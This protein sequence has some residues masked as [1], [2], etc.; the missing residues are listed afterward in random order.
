LSD[1]ENAIRLALAEWLREDK[2]LFAILGILSTL[3]HLCVPSY[4]AT[5][6]ARAR[7][8]GAVCGTQ[9]LLDE[10]LPMS[11]SM[12]RELWHQYLA[13]LNSTDDANVP[14]YYDQL[15][16]EL[17]RFALDDHRARIMPIWGDEVFARLDEMLRE[18]NEHQRL[19]VCS[20]FGIGMD[21][22][23]IHEKIAVEL[24]VT[25]DRVRQLEARAIYNL[26]AAIAEHDLGMISE[27]VGD[28]LERELMR[29]KIAQQ[30]AE[31]TTQEWEQNLF[32][33]VENLAL[34]SMRLSN[35]LRNAGILLVGELVQKSEPELLRTKN[36]SR[37]MLIE[38]REVLDE[39]ELQIGMQ[40]SDELKAA[41]ARRKEEI[42]SSRGLR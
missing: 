28:A 13:T 38:L 15:V 22:P 32:T 29:R 9:I 20:R 5:N 7:L 27:P 36:F 19:V 4:S 17:S 42:L 37:K 33:Q 21:K 24:G 40:I 41:I 16:G 25:R 2:V 23:K 8:L 34:F 11:L 39:L 12:P 3:A 10:L 35:I 18:L 31:A 14:R 26:R 1:D 6:R 30:V